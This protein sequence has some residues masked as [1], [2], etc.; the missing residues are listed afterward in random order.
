[1]ILKGTVTHVYSFLVMHVSCKKEEPMANSNLT[2][3]FAI[4]KPVA[5]KYPNHQIHQKDEKDF[6]HYYLDE[7]LESLS[8]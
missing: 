6:Q 7:T 1:M 5:V 4:N 3:T 2:S 8:F